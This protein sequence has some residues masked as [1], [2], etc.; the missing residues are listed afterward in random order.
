MTMPEGEEDDRRQKRL[1]V[2]S[3]NTRD[4]HRC[5]CQNAAGSSVVT[6]LPR[7]RDA[8]FSTGNTYLR[9]TGS[10]ARA[11]AGTWLAVRAKRY[12]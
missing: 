12:S 5:Y 7:T 4:H 10:A 3:L 11:R 2:S 8:A 9:S 1:T 6:N